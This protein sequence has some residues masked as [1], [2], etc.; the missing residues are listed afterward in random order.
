MAAVVALAVAVAV[1]VTVT[2][3]VVVIV[4]VAVVVVMGMVAIVAV[5]VAMVVVV[6]VI[7]TE[8]D[9]SVSLLSSFRV[10]PCGQETMTN[11]NSAK[12]WVL[13]ELKVPHPKPPSRLHCGSPSML[14]FYFLFCY[15]LSLNPQRQYTASMSN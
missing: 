4:A 10:C 15:L 1:A 9:W 2:G 6:V 8:M 11:A 13:A 3:A 14:L 5:A 12:E 7:M